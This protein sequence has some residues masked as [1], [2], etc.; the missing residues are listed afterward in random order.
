MLSD[1]ISNIEGYV[2]GDITIGGKLDKPSD[3]MLT[4]NNRHDI[5]FLKQGIPFPIPFTLTTAIS[6]SEF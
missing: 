2:A 3:G 4:T 1:N 5:S 6:I